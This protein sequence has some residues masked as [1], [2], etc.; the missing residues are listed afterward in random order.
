MAL[1]GLNRLLIAG[2]L[3]PTFGL[4]LLNEFGRE[5][6]VFG[7][8]MGV[9]TLTGLGL[10]MSTFVGMAFLPLAGALSDRLGNRW[11]I[12]SLGLLPGTLGF[13]LLSLAWPW[14]IAIGLPLTSATSGSNQG[15]AT[16][17]IGDLATT[18]SGRYLG[19]L[20]TMGDLASAIGPL[21][22]FWLVGFVNLRTI[23]LT[24]GALFG[25]MFVLTGWLSLHQPKL[26]ALS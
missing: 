13:M 20:F 24:A 17:L 5:A 4:F 12:T 16:T 21:L 6:T 15:M 25:I 2:T 7:Q 14:A 9:T 8:T 1:I 23:Y 11:R 22:V 19:M 3:A 18:R 26:T 10:S